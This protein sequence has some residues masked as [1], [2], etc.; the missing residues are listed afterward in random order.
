[1]SSDNISQLRVK[2]THFDIVHTILYVCAVKK[3]SVYLKNFKQSFSNSPHSIFY[4]WDSVVL[5][6]SYIC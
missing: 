6:S 4:S 2:I 5:N 3:A 1:M